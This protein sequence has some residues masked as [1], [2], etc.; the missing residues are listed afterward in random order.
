[1]RLSWLGV[2]TVVVDTCA[3]TRPTM[4]E[5]TV[6]S[7]AGSKWLAIFIFELDFVFGFVADSGF[8]E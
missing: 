7:R 8:S 3:E 5:A 2:A 6:K 1:M 4:L